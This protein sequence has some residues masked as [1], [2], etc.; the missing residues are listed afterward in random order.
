MGSS[1]VAF[2][3]GSL[4]APDLSNSVTRAGSL[5]SLHIQQ[6]T[7]QQTALNGQVSELNQVSSAFTSLKSAISTLAS[8]T[9]NN[10]LSADVS[11]SSVVTASASSAAQPGTYTVQVLN[12]G[13]F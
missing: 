2:T 11:D 3:G 1:P 6:L 10:G 5:A 7:N 13:S 4:F 12:P 8:A 9:A